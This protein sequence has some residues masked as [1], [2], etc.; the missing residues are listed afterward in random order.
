MSREYGLCLWTFGDISVE[1][2]CKL[3]KEIGVNGVEVQGDLTQDPKEL[4]K[5][6]VKIAYTH[7]ITLKYPS[8]FKKGIFS[9]LLTS[10][11]FILLIIVGTSYMMY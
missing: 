7:R 9:F 3:A 1:E 8:A 11:L 6:L 5:K 2:K 10:V 4:Q